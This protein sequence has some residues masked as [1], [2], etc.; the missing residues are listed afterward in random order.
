MPEI[1]WNSETY[2]KQHKFVSDF[3]ADVLQWLAPQQNEKI[4]DIG[5]G[6]GDLANKITESGAQVLGTD[7]SAE[8]VTSAQKKYPLQKFAQLDG[9]AL[10]FDQEFDAVFS[11]A[12]FHWIENQKALLHGIYRSL[13]NGGRLVA[14][15]GGKGNIQSIINA[16]TTA[17][18]HLDLSHK[19]ITNFWFFPSVSHYSGLLENVGFE[20]EQIWLFDRPTPLVGDDGMYQWI[21]QF[22][23]HAFKNLN[24]SE[25]E[26][27]K[28]LAVDLLRPEY[29][30]NGTWMADYRRLRVKATKK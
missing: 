18:Q 17:A 1:Y 26:Q 30:H 7:A 16:I 13:K 19:V 3:G 9:T 5:C 22:A 28:K 8:M 14:E 11:N 23:Q 2:D 6:T 27:L 21:N 25:S 10:D 24:E 15:F 29:Y 20:V 12:T 4:L